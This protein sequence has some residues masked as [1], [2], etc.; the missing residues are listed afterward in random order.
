MEREFQSVLSCPVSSVSYAMLVVDLDDLASFSFI[1]PV[2]MFNQV[3]GPV[4]IMMLNI[5]LW[6][7]LTACDTTHS[8][9]CKL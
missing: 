5:C 4:A 9:W 8:L 3:I 2:V 7:L 6:R 1:F